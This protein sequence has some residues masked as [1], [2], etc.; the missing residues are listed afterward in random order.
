MNTSSKFALFWKVNV[1]KLKKLKTA[2][3]LIF[4]VFFFFYTIT[5]NSNCIKTIQNL[6]LYFL[7]IIKKLMNV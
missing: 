3:N 6:N 7:L 4:K 2:K 5:K 1:M